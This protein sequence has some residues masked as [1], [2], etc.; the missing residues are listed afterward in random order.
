MFFF[1]KIL[2]GHYGMFVSLSSI[3]ILFLFLSAYNWFL[4]ITYTSFEG[5]KGTSW[6]NN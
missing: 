4:V 2:V 5:V 3:Q 1:V 6:K